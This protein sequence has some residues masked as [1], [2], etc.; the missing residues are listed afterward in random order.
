[1]TFSVAFP[2]STGTIW[3]AGNVY[4]QFS[5]YMSVSCRFSANNYVNKFTNL[6]KLGGKCLQFIEN[7]AI[8]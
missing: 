6:S 1:M 2:Q 5:A 3:P 4:V 7:V 8:I